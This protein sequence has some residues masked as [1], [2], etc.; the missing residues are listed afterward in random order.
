MAE[1]QSRP[2]IVRFGAFE[3]DVQTGELRKDGVKLKFSGQPFQVLAIL[4]ERPG[5]VVTR[6]ELQKR[7]WPDTFVDVERN[8][9]TAI[10]KIREVLGDSAEQPRFVET[11]PR[12]GYRFIAAVEPEI[13]VEPAA[14][15]DPI[16]PQ[17][18]VRR[19]P[20]SRWMVL[21]GIAV[22]A[23]GAVFLAYTRSGTRRTEV[24]RTLTRL[25]FDEGLQTEP[26]WSPEGTY[27]AYS[28]DRGGKFD[29]W[30][31][32]V[33]GGNPI[34]VTK[35]PGQNWQ[36]DWSPD[37]KYIAYRSEAGD[38][39]IFVIPALGGAGSNARSQPLVTVPDGRRTARRCCSGLT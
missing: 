11:L 36:P 32:Q 9:N 25:T 6:E 33:S 18:S 17:K 21:C 37:G 35:G 19:F 39:G 3:A 10:N 24:Q 16:P 26:T 28:S 15:I 20:I 4:L 2:R 22:L 12:R 14:D 27:I 38:G 13:S 8:L 29:I 7:L 30:V 31:Q 5:E 1:T 23:G 34:Q